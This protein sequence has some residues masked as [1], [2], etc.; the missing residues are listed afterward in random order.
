MDGLGSAAEVGVLLYGCLKSCCQLMNWG[1][2]TNRSRLLEQRLGLTRQWIHNL[3]LPAQA[4]LG[5]QQDHAG[6]CGASPP[7]Q[8][9]RFSSTKTKFN[10]QSQV[11]PRIAAGLA[12]EP[13]WLPESAICATGRTDFR[14]YSLGNSTGSPRD[15]LLACPVSAC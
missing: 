7:R 15:D 8:Y 3:R 14:F 11:N 13:G 4:L 9:V 5:H 1:R 10:V 6:Y 2:R 12:G